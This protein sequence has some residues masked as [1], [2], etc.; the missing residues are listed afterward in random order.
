[1]V[2]RV[3]ADQGYEVVQASN[4]AE[5]LELVDRLSLDGSLKLV[6]TDLAMPLM[7]GRELALR[8][9]DRPKQSAPVPLL[10]ISGYTDDELVRQHLL[11]RGQQFLPKPFSPDALAARVR[12]VVGGR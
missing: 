3:L 2:A 7:G 8:L 1:M 6:V 4:G 9:A 12:R 5:A 11:E 10:F